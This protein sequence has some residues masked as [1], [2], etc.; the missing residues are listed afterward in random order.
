MGKRKEE[1]LRSGKRVVFMKVIG[2]RTR[3]MAMEG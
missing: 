1:G 2:S 3:L